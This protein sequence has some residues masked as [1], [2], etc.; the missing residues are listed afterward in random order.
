M[1]YNFI[2][3]GKA[4]EQ[5]RMQY[6]GNTS[7]GG[8]WLQTLQ[9]LLPSGPTM[10]PKLILLPKQ[11][12]A[13]WV[14]Q[15]R[16]VECL[17]GCKTAPK[18]KQPKNSVIT[19][20]MWDWRQTSYLQYQLVRQQAVRLVLQNRASLSSPMFSSTTIYCCSGMLYF[21]VRTRHHLHLGR[22]RYQC[23]YA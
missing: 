5:L 12:C 4:W 19:E 9:Q 6:T 7:A 15:T 14:L 22:K 13:E 20:H 21:L 23:H 11:M 10:L 16:C 17:Y 8:R 1:K 18:N 3:Q 2:A